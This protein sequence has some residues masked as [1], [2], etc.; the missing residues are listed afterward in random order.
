MKLINLNTNKLNRICYIALPVFFFSF[1]FLLQVAPSRNLQV[2]SVNHFQHRCAWYANM[3][4]SMIGLK[5]MC[6]YFC[7]RR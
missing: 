7:I 2:S 5:Y 1:F 4:S 6:I 3:F